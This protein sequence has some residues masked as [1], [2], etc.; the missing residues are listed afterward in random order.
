MPQP[1]P[2]FIHIYLPYGILQ[3]KVDS[4]PR[5]YTEHFWKKVTLAKERSKERQKMLR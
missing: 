5:D 2:P 1:Q 3:S 4:R